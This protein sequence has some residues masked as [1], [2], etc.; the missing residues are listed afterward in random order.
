MNRIFR[1]WIGTGLAGLAI[2]LYLAPSGLKAPRTVEAASIPSTATL[3]GTVDSPKPFKAAQVYIRNA[4]KRM[5]YMVYTVGGHYRAMDLFPGD[6]EVSVK[7]K[8]L[9]SGTTKLT[10]KAGQNATANFSLHES[11]A[12]DLKKDV[13]YQKF[14]EIY[15]PGPGLDVAKK[16]CFYCHGQD[17][18]PTKHWNAEQWNFALDYM[19]GVGNRQGRMIQPEDM[20]QQERETLLQYVVRNFGPN[21]TTR[22]VKIERDMPVDETKLANAE[23][24]EYYLPADPPGKGIDDP[25]YAN[26]SSPFGHRRVSQ[27]PQLDQDGNV[28][29]TDRGY[30]NRICKL[31]PRTGEYKE[32]LTPQPKAGVHDLNIDNNGI[33]WVPENEGIPAGKPKLQAFNPKTEKWQTAYPFNPDK[34]IPDDVFIHAQSIAIDSKQNIYV[35]HIYGNGLAKWNRATKKITTYRMPSPNS[36]PYGVVVD[37]ND[38]VWIAE[39]RRSKV[40]KLDAKTGKFTEYAP[41]TRPAL[42]RR[43]NVDTDGTTIWFGLFSAG[44]LERLDPLTGKIT[45]YKIPQQVSQPY[46]VVVEN[47]QVWISDA[48][49]GGALIKFN[50]KDQS[51]TYFPSPQRADMPKIRLTREGAIWYAPRSSQKFPGLGV[52]YPDVTKITTLAAYR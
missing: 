46:D 3:S 17:F 19:T 34:V 39:S 21:S 42:I 50:P 44:K 15:P 36:M 31:D 2:T 52:L 14:D 23:Y 37:K 32:Y 7:A 22:A 30:P 51:F 45:E 43:L 48:G 13:T 9:D 28:W 47:G 49:Q 4:D 24:I 16:T 8:D 5:L 10:L 27:D 18:L 25:E 20:N 38:N 40:A 35:V 1:F 41:P 26:F 11:T 29:L 12:S 33:I 6:Y